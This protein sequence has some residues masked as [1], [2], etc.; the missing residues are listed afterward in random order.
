MMRCKWRGNW[1]CKA[2]GWASPLRLT[3]STGHGGL[4]G[5]ARGTRR[6]PSRAARRGVG[7]RAGLALGLARW[8]TSGTIGRSSRCWK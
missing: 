4:I 5:E 2:A 1:R 8:Q 7:R 3:C 6:L